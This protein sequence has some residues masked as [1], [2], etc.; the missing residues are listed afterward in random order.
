MENGFTKGENDGKGLRR[1][2]VL[3]LW[4]LFC[5]LGIMLTRI[6]TSRRVISL[7]FL[8][9]DYFFVQYYIYCTISID[10]SGGVTCDTAVAFRHWDHLRF[11][12]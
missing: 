2:R 12:L 11:D 10:S 7:Q 1:R 3:S 8:V 9:V 5:T 6:G 4:F